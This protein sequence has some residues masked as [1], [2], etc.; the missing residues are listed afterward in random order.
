MSQSINKTPFCTLSGEVVHGRGIG[1]LVGMPTA[2]LRLTTEIELPP[3]GVYV[4]KIKYDSHIYY[5]ITNIGLRPT[6]DND[7]T[8]SIETHI[9]NFEQRIYGE[10]LELQLF[11]LLR[12]IKKFEDFSSLLEQIRKDCIAVQDFFGIEGTCSRLVMN[13]ERHQV[14]IDNQEVFLTNKEFAVL[15]MLYSNPDV[16]FTKEQIFEA[17]WQEPSAGFYHAVENT[18]FQIRKKCKEVT[19]NKDFIKTVVGYGYKFSAS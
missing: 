19:E 15:Y 10:H 4:T 14:K 3:H 5:G 7:G 12:G 16:A 2:N 13:L 8:I 11:K 18:V 9:L 6:I 17:V 1:K